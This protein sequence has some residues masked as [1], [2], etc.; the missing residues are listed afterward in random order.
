MEMKNQ[1]N[2]MI[3]NEM[4]WMEMK[5]QWNEIIGNEMK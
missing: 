3:G 1:W 5:N 4:K 2:E